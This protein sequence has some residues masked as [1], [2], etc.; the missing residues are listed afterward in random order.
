MTGH[1][2]T[3][4]FDESGMGVEKVPGLFEQALSMGQS[5][6]YFCAFPLENDLTRSPSN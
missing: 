5:R 1:E 4:D 3:L 2:R 6:G